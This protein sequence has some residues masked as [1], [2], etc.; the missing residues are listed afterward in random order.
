[1]VRRISAS[2]LRRLIPVCLVFDTQNLR[3]RSGLP[4]PTTRRP[5]GQTGVQQLRVPG[6]TYLDVRRSDVEMQH[7]L[8]VRSAERLGK[9][10]SEIEDPAD[11][12]RTSACLVQ[13]LPRHELEYEEQLVR[14]VDNLE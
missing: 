4:G 8:G 5:A 1:M 7:A 3:R 10:N 2:L 9:L 6:Q 11:L 13:G 12:E 14:A